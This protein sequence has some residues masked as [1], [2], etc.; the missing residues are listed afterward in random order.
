[1]TKTE[2]HF[3]FTAFVLIVGM[4]MVAWVSAVVVE[5]SERI[6][7]RMVTQSGTTGGTNGESLFSDHI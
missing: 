1:M 3:A 2:Q 4:L 6:V 5:G 7:E